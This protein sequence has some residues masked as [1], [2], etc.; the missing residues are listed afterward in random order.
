MQEYLENN[1]TIVEDF[2]LIEDI[3]EVVTPAIFGTIGCCVG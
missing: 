2:D 1:E 3:E